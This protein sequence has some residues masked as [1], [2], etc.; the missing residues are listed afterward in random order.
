MLCSRMMHTV[1][2]KYSEDSE[3]KMDKHIAGTVT[4]TLCFISY[5]LRARHAGN[6]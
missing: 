2:Q 3:T 1:S 6:R 5:K 4:Y